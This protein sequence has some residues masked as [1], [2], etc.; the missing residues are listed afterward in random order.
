[1]SAP[2]SPNSSTKSGRSAADIAAIGVTGMLPAVV[3]LDG[4]GKL[5]RRSIQQSDGRVGREVEEIAAEF[6]GEN[7][8]RRTGNG[9]NQQ[10]VATK[11]RWLERHEPDV[12]NKIATVFGSYDYINHRLTGERVIEH[13]WALE[14]GF[15]KVTSRRLDAELVALGHI[16]PSVLPPVRASHELIGKVTPAAA[17]ATGLAVGTPV[18]AGSADHVTSAFVAGIR[19]D[20]DCLIKFGGA[21]DIM[22][23]A[24]EPDTGPAPVP[25]LPYRPRQF[26]A[27]RLHGRSGAI[28]NWLV[29]LAG[30]AVQETAKPHAHLD[31]LAARIAPG[32]DG[33][34]LLP[35]FLGEKTPIHDPDARGT[36]VGLG[37]HH[38][39]G[40]VWRAALE[41]V[42]FGFRHHL[43]V[44]AGLGQ[45][46]KH[47]LAS[48]GGAA[49]LI[50]MQIAADALGQ[51][52]HLLK[53][54]PG[55]CL[56]AAY[57]AA[58]AVGAVSDWDGIS[59]FVKPA[60][61]IEPN[62]ENRER[63]DAL[64]GLY[65]EI[66]RSL[67]PIYPKLAALT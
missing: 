3:L 12:F 42:V 10:L 57:I 20:G 63:Y 44:F 49:S 53:G 17:A 38:T 39:I 65:R 60:G 67:R 58:F 30:Q 52:I 19:E 28:L 7:F 13:N 37:L 4:N 51:P 31:Q 40:H 33:L 23:A 48:D 55:S 41:A 50:W 18:I 27:Q 46:A 66:Y 62:A 54:H 61:L 29:V 25:R 45:P 9:I 1:M 43:D 16:D 2:S 15:L 21:G 22:L 36:L 24:A 11:L 59:R 35:Y 14:A 6:D 64:Y 47:L 8:V 26:T 32:A 5:L 34:I 56:G